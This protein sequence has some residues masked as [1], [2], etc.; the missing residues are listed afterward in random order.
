MRLVQPRLAD[1]PH[2]GRRRRHALGACL[3]SP[4]VRSI[5]TRLHVD[6][7]HV[8]V[9]QALDG[10]NDTETLAEEG[11]AH[12]TGYA[13]N[14]EQADLAQ[15]AFLLQGMA[16]DAYLASVSCGGAADAFTAHLGSI[17]LFVASVRLH[18]RGHLLAKEEGE[19]WRFL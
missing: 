18:L 12:L 13:D 8:S 7:R 17:N 14:A 3:S 19:T 9:L 11:G 1:K 4:A 10:F 16:V 15:R 6:T 5:S 2:H